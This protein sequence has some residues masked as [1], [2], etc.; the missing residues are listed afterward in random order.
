M[1]DNMRSSQLGSC[2]ATKFFVLCVDTRRRALRIELA[3]RRVER[4]ELRAYRPPGD[5]TQRGFYVKTATFR[6]FAASACSIPACHSFRGSGD[7]G[8]RCV[9]RQV[10]NIAKCK[11]AR[12][13]FHGSRSPQPRQDGATTSLRRRWVRS[14]FD[15]CVRP[16][17]WVRD[18]TEEHAVHD[19]PYPA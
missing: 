9:F 2:R 17:S 14:D 19:R 10:C 7:D 5:L 4:R 16:N 1:F 8:T 15:G 18:P 3:L 11:P 13:R 12:G 6:R